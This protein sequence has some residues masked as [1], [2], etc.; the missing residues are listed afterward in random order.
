MTERFAKE[1]D[2]LNTG[3]KIYIYTV[4]KKITTTVL[5]KEATECCSKTHI[6][7]VVF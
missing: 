7:A 5:T 1:S 2:P 4:Y 6:S 3:K